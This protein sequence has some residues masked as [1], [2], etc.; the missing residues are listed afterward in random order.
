MQNQIPNSPS[1][2]FGHERTANEHANRARWERAMAEYVRSRPYGDI[3]ADAHERTAA[4]YEI[5][6]QELSQETL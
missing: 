5:R 6:V 1:T 2:P 3:L 4:A